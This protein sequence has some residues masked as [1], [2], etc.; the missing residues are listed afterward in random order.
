MKEKKLNEYDRP[1]YVAY[2]EFLPFARIVC[3]QI[4][5][6]HFLSL[7]NM[8]IQFSYSFGKKIIFY[9]CYCK[10]F[11]LRPTRFSMQIENDLGIFSIRVCVL[12]KTQKMCTNK[13]QI[14]FHVILVLNF[15]CSKVKARRKK[16][17]QSHFRNIKL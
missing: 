7:Y 1:I 2:A 16:K 3:L 5:D 15:R 12:R 17:I 9:I 8:Y 11:R 4:L 6:Y 14:G 13:S 10:H